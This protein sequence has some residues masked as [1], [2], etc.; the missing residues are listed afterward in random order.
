M[1]DPFPLPDR[2][3][4]SAAPALLQAL[5]HHRGQ[6]LALDAAGVQVIGALALEVVVAAG[7]QWQADGLPLSIDR[8]SPRFR[9][10]CGQLGLDPDQPWR[11][12]AEAGA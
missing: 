8:P 1:T 3:D 11:M 5:L 4:S 7:R 12:M 2:L 6:P 10:I 9:A